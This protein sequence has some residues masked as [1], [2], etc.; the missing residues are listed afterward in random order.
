[1][2]IYKYDFNF[3]IFARNGVAEISLPLGS[4]VLSIQNQDGELKLWALVDETEELS[5]TWHYYVFGTGLYFPD[6]SDLEYV[7]TVQVN[8]LVWHIFK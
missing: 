1:M 4:K 2:K 3:T 7:T 6:K 5:H 8:E